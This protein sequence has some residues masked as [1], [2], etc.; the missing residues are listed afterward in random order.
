MHVLTGWRFKP[1]DGPSSSFL[2]LFCGVR[3]SIASRVRRF[4]VGVGAPCP[5][6]WAGSGYVM[7][8]PPD[9]NPT[10]GRARLGCLEALFRMD[11]VESHGPVAFETRG[12]GGWNEAG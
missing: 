10:P 1:N 11:S 8:V 12:N 9:P 6:D 7:V 4:S 5:G 3:G 2:F